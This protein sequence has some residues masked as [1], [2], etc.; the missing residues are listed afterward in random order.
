M[1]PF[2]MRKKNKPYTPHIN[3]NNEK[4]R[5]ILWTAFSRWVINEIVKVKWEAVE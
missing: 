3:I 2:G 4:R 1:A 5:F